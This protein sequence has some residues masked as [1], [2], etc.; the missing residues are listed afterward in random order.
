VQNGTTNGIA[1][2]ALTLVDS[3][4]NATLGTTDA[5]GAFSFPNMAAGLYSLQTVAPGYVL[6]AASLTIPVASFTVQLAKQGTAPVTT[7]TVAITGPSALSV[8]RSV[9][10]MASVVYTDGT[11]KDVTNVATW[12]STVSS[13][14][15]VSSTG[16]MT[17]YSV[18]STAITAAF[19]DV[20]GS[21]SV[22][23][24]SP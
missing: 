14:A 5:T 23:T 20:T 12:R 6:S 16:L 8:G 15:T 9:Q 7:L 11:Q 10:L 2:A 24:T 19:Q 4:G 17:A 18:G 1:Q 3:T 21:L 22:N 13:V